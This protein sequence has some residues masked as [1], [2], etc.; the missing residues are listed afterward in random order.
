MS[1]E[2]DVESR[3]RSGRTGPATDAPAGERSAPGGAIDDAA[4]ESTVGDESRPGTAT[5]DAA[6]DGGS[7][8]SIDGPDA[9]ERAVGAGD[10]A[11]PRAAGPDAWTAVEERVQLSEEPWWEAD[12]APPPHPDA[13]PWHDADAESRSTGRSGRSS[14]RSGGFSTWFGSETR[15]RDLLLAVVGVVALV[16]VVLTATAWLA[17]AVGGP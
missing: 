11:V 9:V 7:L 16:L 15:R 10:E 2:D 6:T 3:G 17:T 14:G 13:R 4:P 8:D 1:G 12:G 5:D